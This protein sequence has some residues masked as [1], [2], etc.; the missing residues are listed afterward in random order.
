[1]SAPLA[2]T[3]G[4]IIAALASIV[5][6]GLWAERT[7]IGR[8]VSAPVCI[9]LLAA[10]LANLGVLPHRSVVYDGV[11]AYLVPAAVA[12]FMLKADLVRIVRQSGRT[13]V[14]FFVGGLASVLGI[15]AAAAVFAL[16]ADE[17]AVAALTAANLIG[18]TVNVIA[19]AEVVGYD[20]PTRFAAL[21]SGAASVAMVYLTVV[22]VLAGNAALL[23][24]FPQRSA[25]APSELPPQTAGVSSAATLLAPL[26]PILIAVAIVWAS[27]SIAQWLAVPHLSLVVVTLLALALANL[28]PRAMGRMRSD[29][30]LGTLAMFTFFATIGAAVQLDQVLGPAALIAGFM[31]LATAVHLLLLLPVAAVLRLGLAET[32]IGSVAAVA[33]P[34]TAAAFA[35][36]REWHGFVLPG[37]L[38]GML[39]FGIGTLVGL[40]V[41]S[42]FAAWH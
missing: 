20:D 12:L 29:T 35:A 41:F 22:G 4:Q 23:R 8:T 36:G 27:K 25:P 31:A 10:M 7:V 16:G 13:L 6:F 11:V 19:V 32:L 26:V 30:V 17:P 39:G 18:G 14:A 24:R 15:G 40:G 37:I 33:G 3:P 5:A 28:F 38:T 2:A 21:V 1:M 42:A 34:T 9:L